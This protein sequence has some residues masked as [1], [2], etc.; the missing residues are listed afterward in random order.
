M[1]PL[2]R[3]ERDLKREGFVAEQAQR[4][5]VRHTQRL[6]DELLLDRHAAP[7]RASW[8]DLLLRRRRR[9]PGLAP[10]KGLYFWGGVGRGKTYLVDAFYDCLPE[11]RKLRLHF[12]GFMLRVHRELKTLKGLQSPLEVVADRIAR[13]ARVLCFEE[14][15]VSDITDAMLLGNL[16][17]ALFARSVTLVATS[18]E[19]PDR[20]YH[21]GLQRERF[22]PAIALLKTHTDVVQVYGGTDFRLRALEKAEIFHSPLDD[23]ADASLRASF[24]AIAPAAGEEG[25]AI[26]VEGRAIAT[27]R[28]ADGVAW[29]EFREIC[30][31]L[32]AAADYIE[33]AR[34]HQTVLISNVPQM[35]DL[36]NDAA[37]RF[38]H[39]VDEFY[40]RNVKLI[41]SAAAAPTALYRGERLARPFERTASRLR[42]MQSHEYL[43]RQHI[44]D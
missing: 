16:L 37:R 2:Q 14:F 19:H 11:G 1:T 4:A 31:G 9:E 10:V 27:V 5:A 33:V 28:R 36:S 40:D 26:E 39:L 42:E 22:L 23:G 41:L 35:D 12:H 24:E 8:F 38:I 18:N 43:A 13:D 29:F 15:H 7:S 32:R 20:L 17:R 3:Y 25:G 30:E 34:C 44:S 6:Y 21:G